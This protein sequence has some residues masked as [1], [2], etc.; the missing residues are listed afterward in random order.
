[1]TPRLRARVLAGGAL[2][3]AGA[4]TACTPSPAGYA[5]SVG[6]Q[7]VT[8]DQVR[9]SADRL[10][11]AASTATGEVDRATA[12]SFTLNYLLEYALSDE[13]AARQ[14][15]PITVDQ[16]EIEAIRGQFVQAAGG[17]DQLEQAY[18]QQ[19]VAP[20]TENRFLRWYLIQVKLGE[21]LVPG[22]QSDAVQAQRQEATNALKR[23]VAAQVGVKV[24]PRYGSYDPNALTLTPLQ[25]GGLATGSTPTP[26]AAPLEG[27]DGSGAG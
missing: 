4:L 11:A 25:S 21:Q 13:V 22:A 14:S 23:Q 15:P 6:D 26:S 20:G 5:V 16:S 8:N 2:L 10:F 19:G 7:R 3:L 12:V 18:L 24:S 27:T 17:E 9:D 1:M